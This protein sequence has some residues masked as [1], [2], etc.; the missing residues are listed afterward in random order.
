MGGRGG[1]QRG[2][3]ERKGAGGEGCAE[4]KTSSPM[5]KL[6]AMHI[7]MQRGNGR[8][9]TGSDLMME[10]RCAAAQVC[11]EARRQHPPLVASQAR[12]AA[13][14]MNGGCCSKGQ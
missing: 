9:H 4:Q 3:G 8:Q 2:G 14:A 7:G 11:A 12:A 1:W 13:A 5:R 6:P 10:A